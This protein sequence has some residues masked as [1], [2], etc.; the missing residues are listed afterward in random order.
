MP[1]PIAADAAFLV[2]DAKQIAHP[3]L[4]GSTAIGRDESNAVVLHDPAASR[5]H[6]EVRRGSD[7][8]SIRSM[9]AMGTLVN[10]TPVEQP[11]LLAEGDVVA[12]AFETFRF[13]RTAPSGPVR[14]ATRAPGLGRSAE[15][16]KRPTLQPGER[17]VVEDQNPAARHTRRVQL[18]V[19]LGL[20]LAVVVWWILR[21]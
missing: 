1:E 8:F 17:V 19:G 7:G 6:A 11:R 13:T 2:N 3:L 15:S 16:A 12:L 18:L 5:F 4:P 14:L 9:G 21:H 20:V 10:G